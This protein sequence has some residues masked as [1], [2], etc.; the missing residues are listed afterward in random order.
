MKSVRIRD[1]ASTQ[2]KILDTAEKLFSDNGFS[3]T[4]IGKI[5][6]ESGVSDGL[7]LHHYKT[8]DNL[9]T[10]VRERVA[11]RYNLVLNAKKKGT[12]SSMDGI[13]GLMLQLFQTAF[14]FFKK[15]RIYHRISLWS[16]LEGKTDVVE[17]E[18]VIT[19]KLVEM[20][21]AGQTAG[22]L[23]DDFDPVVLLTMT[24]GSIHYWLRYR[25]QFKKIL[26][27]NDSLDNLDNRF[28]EQVAR[29]LARSVKKG[30][31]K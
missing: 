8:K 14:G 25:S 2:A 3:G 4:S 20:V 24:I 21:K 10:A 9:Y 29:L 17:K 7:I 31:N 12:G 26:H 15:N 28:L 27:I 5:S 19:G 30:D 1:G 23:E 22:L 6:K 16:Y 11:N 18:A 13:G